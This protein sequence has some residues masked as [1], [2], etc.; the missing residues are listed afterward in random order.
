MITKVV[1][2]IAVMSLPCYG[3]LEQITDAYMC[4]CISLLFRVVV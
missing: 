3:V 4:E 2:Y 1:L